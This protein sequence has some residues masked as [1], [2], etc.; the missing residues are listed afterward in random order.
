[1]K[2]RIEPLLDDRR[3][4][5]RLAG[6]ADEVAAR[7]WSYATAVSEVHVSRMS[8]A[9]WCCPNVYGPNIVFVVQGR[10][11]AD[12]GGEVFRYDPDHYVVFAVPLPYEYEWDATPGEPLLAVSPALEPTL[13]GEV[14]VVMDEPVPGEGDGEDGGLPRGISSTPI[15]PDLGD[16]VARLL[17]CL[18]T[19]AEARVL[20][21]QTVREIV[22]RVLRGERG[23]VLRALACREEH[24]TR[25]ARVLRHPHAEYARPHINN[26]L[27]RRAGMSV[28]AF[29]RYF[30]AVT[31]TSPLQ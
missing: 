27:A 15:T 1:M 16:S 28:S 14:L 23:G 24:F 22:Y 20:G 31:A 21:R 12:L 26:D 19:P 10:K 18:R 6:L 2:S 7:E 13:L 3:S 25:I 17:E 5:T 30:K 8:G 11:R 9:M 29:H 4:R